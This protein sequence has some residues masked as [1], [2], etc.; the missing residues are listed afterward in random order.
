MKIARSNWLAQL[1]RQRQIG[2]VLTITVQLQ[3]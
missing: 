3:Y 2:D 1:T